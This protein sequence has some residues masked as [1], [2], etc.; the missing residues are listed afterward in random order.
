MVKVIV[1][2]GRDFSNYALCKNALDKLYPTTDF[3]VVSG[4]ARGA[5]TLGERYAKEHGRCIHEFPADWD[6]Y[7]K[8]AGYLRNSDM[9]DFADVLVAFWDGSSKG[10]KHMIDLARRKGLV[11]HVVRY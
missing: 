5:D 2:G 11:V 7:G 8:R 9:A 4:K 3:D 1:A 10:T 6:T